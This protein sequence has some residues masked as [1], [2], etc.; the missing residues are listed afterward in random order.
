MRK[1]DK[2]ILDD[3]QRFRV[4]SRDDIA[5]IHFTNV[6]NPVTACNIVLKRLR[7]D[8]Y[9][10]ANTSQQPYNYFLSPNPMKKNSQKIPHFL[11]IVDA[12]RQLCKHNKP[13]QFI[14]EPKYGKDYMEPDAFMIF[15]DS[16]FFVEIQRNVYSKKVM[17]EKIQRYEAYYYSNQWQS[18]AWQ[19]V[20]N[21]VF[22]YVLMLTDTRYAIESDEIEVFQ[23]K[24]IDEL[25]LTV[26]NN[27]NESKERV[28]ETKV[29]INTVNK[30]PSYYQR[31][32]QTP[33]PPMYKGTSGIRINLS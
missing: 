7:R 26:N 25:M 12:Y 32:K 6:K 13:E 16:P 31:P 28:N 23:V 22:P 33:K 11:A 1:R 17:K 30:K 5:A 9:V 29:N 2:A 10:E 8:G 3:L 24:N 27:E 15:N 21:K 18:E 20:D 4:M 14:V 19:T